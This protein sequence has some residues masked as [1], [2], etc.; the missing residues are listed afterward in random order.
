MVPLRLNSLARSRWSSVRRSKTRLLAVDAFDLYPLIRPSGTFSPTVVFF[1]ESPD[2]LWG[3]RTFASAPAE[4]RV[5][6]IRE[7]YRIRPPMPSGPCRGSR[8]HA[9]RTTQSA[10]R[11]EVA[12]PEVRLPFGTHI[13]SPGISPVDHPHLPT[14]TEA[15]R[16]RLLF[17]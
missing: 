13:P 5:D 17:V 16:C 2:R 14:R 6:L 15:Q 10:P 12:L 9:R 1:C 11:P 8:D 3:R 4:T 7:L